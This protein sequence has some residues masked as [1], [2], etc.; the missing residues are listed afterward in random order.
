MRA[1]GCSETEFL[2]HKVLKTRKNC[3]LSLHW[4]LRLKQVGAPTVPSA[5]I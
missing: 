3:Q 5:V 4:S 2:L 1:Q